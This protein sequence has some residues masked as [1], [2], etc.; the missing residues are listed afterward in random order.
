[1]CVKE[2]PL[3]AF[4]AMDSGDAIRGLA[5]P[6]LTSSTSYGAPA[7]QQVMSPTPGTPAL[8]HGT[9]AFSGSTPPLETGH[10]GA[11]GFEPMAAGRRM[12]GPVVKADLIARK[13]NH[14]ASHILF[15]LYTTYQPGGTGERNLVLSNLQNPQVIYDAT[16][17][18][19][20]LGDWG[21]WYQR[22]IDFG[23]N[24]PDPMVLVGALNSMTKPVISKDTEVTWRTE[25]VKSTLQLHARP[26]AEAVTAYHRHLLAEFEALATSQVPKKGGNQ[27]SNLA[28]KATDGTAEGNSGGQGG[29]AKGGGKGKIPCKYFLSQKGCRYGGSCK[30]VHSMNELS[31]G[32]RCKKCLN[33]GSEEHRAKDC[34]R[35][36]KA[37][38]SGPKEQNPKPGAQV[39]QVTPYT[40]AASTSQHVV[41]ATPVLSPIFSS[42]QLRCTVS[43]R[44]C[45]FLRPLNQGLGI[46]PNGQNQGFPDPHFGG[47]NQG[48]GRGENGGFEG[49]NGHIC[50]KSTFS[51]RELGLGPEEGFRPIAY[52]LLDSGATHPMRQAKDQ[53]EWDEALEVQVSLAGDKTTCMRLTQSGTLLLPPLERASSVQPIV[54]MGAVI[55]QL[56]YSV[57]WSA[58]SCK[59]YP[60]NGKPLRLRVKNGCPEVP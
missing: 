59:L 31:K 38:K 40:S 54:P 24:L 39:A 3:C 9:R 42:K 5:T 49:K 36:N 21:R 30:N 25:M 58:G 43:S 1:M 26:T 33:C 7:H 4:A 37:G 8:E 52:A 44:Q 17:G 14:S 29:G 32:D 57:V 6:L 27:P 13:A 51:A 34:D 10:S 23:M 11:E 16:A 45:R 18:V 35:P 15:R 28:L 2:P 53:R 55:E 46:A 56:G 12:T 19:A 48:L 41:Q 50:P 22:C 60:P 20:A 47:E